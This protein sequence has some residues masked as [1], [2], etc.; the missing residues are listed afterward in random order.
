MPTRLIVF[1]LFA[2]SAYAANPL[3][4][5]YAVI[6]ADA[7]LSRD[8]GTLSIR[9]S[10]IGS[11]QATLTRE[12]N[13][14]AIH[15]SGSVKLLLNAVFVRVPRGSRPDLN[16]LPGVKTIVRLRPLKT[17][18]NDATSLVQ[19]NPG[20]WSNPK[21]GGV[22]N[23]GA[24]IKI[25]IIDTGIDD[26][27]P[28][29]N[30]AN[31]AIPSGYPMGD[32]A[33]T[34]H[35]IIVA[36]SYVSYLSST[37]PRYSSPDDLSP[38]DRVGHG[39]AVAMIA[40]GRTV[41]GPATTVSTAP[42]AITGVAPEAW[43]GNY[44]IFGSPG[45]NDYAAGSAVIQAL[46]DAALDGMQ[47][48]TLALGN[49]ALSA[50]LDT[51]CAAN[52]QS[53]KS[54]IPATSCDVEAQ[55]IENAVNQLGITVV[56]SAGDSGASGNVYPTLGTITSPGTAPS[57][58]TV[59]ATTN[60]HDFDAT[61]Y[62]TGN[63]VPAKQFF[64]AQFGAG[65]KPAAAFTAPLIDVTKTGDSGMACSALPANSLNGAVAL[66]IRGTCD[67]AT[68][69]NNVQAA[70]AVALLLYLDDPNDGL[71]VPV[72]LAATAIPTVLIGN[73]DGIQLKAFAANNALTV[74][75]DPAL[76][77]VSTNAD[78]VASFS[79]RG[80]SIG[81]FSLS[82][83]LAIKP[84]LVAPGTGIYTATQTLDPNGSFYDPSGFNAAQ[85]TSFAVPLVA[86]AVALV[87]QAN[88][89]FTP[90]E[91]KSAVVNTAAAGITDNGVPADV[92][93]VGAGKLDAAAALNV[94]L[95][96]VPVHSFLRRHQRECPRFVSSRTEFPAHQRQQCVYDG[97]HQPASLW[98]RRRCGHAHH[99]VHRHAGSGRIADRL[100]ADRGLGPRGRFLSGRNR[101][102]RQRSPA[103]CSVPL[104][105]H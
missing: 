28:A 69:A 59:G 37:D 84:E 46:E 81:L 44:K 52:G 51:D 87:K 12:L 34:N 70:G 43:I 22:S 49:T 85:G 102:R 29:F 15:V 53:T 13:A 47:I 72:N 73:A 8:G 75:L 9:S 57:A 17:H 27:N 48:V 61:V 76:F 94:T 66:V 24:G 98:N 103:A 78:Q 91:L 11:Q 20:A 32:A 105:G 58:I 101:Y 45:V 25:G 39:T 30:D 31:L 68:K 35:K 26:L 3:F 100:A 89:N 60:A 4:D 23:A 19:V 62:V 6:L 96:C 79:S 36:R 82:P 18:L 10:N 80:P 63:G 14:R 55:A 42:L 95:A 21:I 7:P 88:P 40:A 77:E 90:G 16:G 67:F 97:F 93:A 5:E 65:P 41:T 54:Y 71:F 33:Y 2:A 83:V 104:P 50:P 64:E 99:P 1:L 86:G 56:T 92:N 74:T 38:V